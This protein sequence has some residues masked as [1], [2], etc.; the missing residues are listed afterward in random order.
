MYSCCCDL[1][2]ILYEAAP[3]ADGHHISYNVHVQNGMIEN[4]VHTCNRADRERSSM[5]FSRLSTCT[6][7]Y[8]CVCTVTCKVGILL[9]SQDI[10]NVQLDSG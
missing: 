7:K 9:Q 5:Q 2:L 1:T 3:F 6:V 8:L 4:A 10:T